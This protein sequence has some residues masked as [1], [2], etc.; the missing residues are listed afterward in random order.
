M[1]FEEWCRWKEDEGSEEFQQF[2]RLR[3]SSSDAAP[4]EFLPQSVQGSVSTVV[5]IRKS[6]LIVNTGAEYKNLFG[7][8]T[9]SRMPKVPTMQV[10]G[11]DGESET[12]L[13]FENPMAPF[14][15]MEVETEYRDTC[16]GTRLDPTANMYEGHAPRIWRHCVGQRHTGFSD[17][18]WSVRPPATLP[19]LEA[20]AE[21][22]GPEAQEC[23]QPTLERFKLGVVANEGA[24]GAGEGGDGDRDPA[25]GSVVVYSKPQSL[26]QKTLAT[27]TPLAK[28]RRVDGQLLRA[29]PPPPGQPSSSA[30]LAGD[31]DSAIDPADSASMCDEGM[32][33]DMDVRKLKTSKEKLARLKFK[34]PL[35]G[36]MAKE[37]L[38]RQEYSGRKYLTNKK[39]DEP[40]VKMLKQHFKLVRMYVCRGD[41]VTQAFGR[42]SEVG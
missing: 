14:R 32:D 28:K 38:G 4:A 8:N 17:D 20:H 39:L 31:G 16:L 5:R 11:P 27:T 9:T 7:R 34:L 42:F 21:K 22:L 41:P 19:T 13:C 3:S 1:S 18:A 29:S 36:F 35:V 10:Q 2:V 40:D 15:T 26:L 23:L 12:V 30:N 33:D 25:S 24:A 37:K 6:M